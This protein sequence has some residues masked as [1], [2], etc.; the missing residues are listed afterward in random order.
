VA[1]ALVGRPVQVVT[2]SLAIA[3]LLAAAKE[4]D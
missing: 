1:R 2:N 3:G 4:T